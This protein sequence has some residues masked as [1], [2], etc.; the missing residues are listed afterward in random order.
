MTILNQLADLGQAIWLDYIRRSF[1]DQGK[2]A[3]LVASGLR[4]VTSNPSIFEKAIAGSA[5]Y[6]S[7]I[8]R[9]A[10]AGKSTE[11]IYT[12]LSCSD[13]QQAADTLAPVYEQ[14]HGMDGFVSLEV[15]P[16]YAHDTDQTARE[17]LRLWNLVDRPNLMVKIPATLE[18]LPAITA[19]LEAGVNVNVTLIFSLERYQQVMKAHLRGLE[20]RLEKGLPID[21]VASVASFFVSRIDNK[22]DK[23]LSTLVA[24]GGPKALAASRLLGKAAVANAKLA[25][26]EFLRFTQTEAYREIKNAGAQVQR[27]LW[28]S[29]STKNPAYSDILYVQTLIGRHTVNTLP[30]ETLEAF[31]D[32]GEAHLTIADDFSAASE[33]FD[34]L[35]ELGISIDRIT[36]ELEVEGVGAFSSAF[37]GMLA[38]IDAK[39]LQA[40]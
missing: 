24:Q 18:G 26:Q 27:P 21:G 38:S 10:L 1:I 13:I 9:F 14:T 7:D 12:L 40:I 16:A 3:N 4:G 5:D 34:S 25:Y 19:A 6:A 23:H 35:A 31:I 39:R 8:S 2:L 28:A 20:R 32:H 15:S 11:E 22:A 36:D 37:E 29:T 33:V 17:A 30:Q